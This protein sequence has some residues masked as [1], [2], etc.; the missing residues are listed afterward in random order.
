MSLGLVIAVRT[1]CDRFVHRI[2]DPDGGIIIPDTDEEMN[3]HAFLAHSLDMQG[4]RADWFVGRWPNAQW[5]D[6]R[7]LHQRGLGVTELASLWEIGPIRHALEHPGDAGLKTVDDALCVLRQHGGT[8]GT[9]LAEALQTARMRKNIRT[10]RAYLQNSHFLRAHGFSFRRHLECRTSELLPGAPFPPT[11]VMRPVRWGGEEVSLEQALARCL[12]RD[13][14][15]VGPEIAAYMLCDWLLG[16]WHRKRI[17]WFESCKWDSRNA[18]Y[19]AHHGTQIR[20]KADFLAWCREQQLP[21]PP[22]V[23]NEAVW[24]WTE[25][26]RSPCLDAD[27]SR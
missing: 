2:V 12:E 26:E 7:T 17:P 23:V 20:S 9:S 14:H 11:D 5:S 27:R 6:F 21:Y 16:L 4:F 25:S 10:I 3:W 19:F 1:A 18:E 24:L 8:I 22:R 15:L 13:F